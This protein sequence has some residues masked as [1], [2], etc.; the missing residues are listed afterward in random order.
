MHPSIILSVL[1]GLCLCSKG[2]AAPSNNDALTALDL[3]PSSGF[4]IADT[5]ALAIDAD[6]IRGANSLALTRTAE[7]PSG[8]V[9]YTLSKTIDRDA[10]VSFSLKGRNLDYNY[11]IKPKIDGSSLDIQVIDVS[12]SAWQTVIVPVSAPSQRTF[13]IEFQIFSEAALNAALLIDDFKLSYG[14]QVRK[15]TADG[16]TLSLSPD[17]RAYAPTERVTIEALP[18]SGYRVNS[19]ALR[20]LSGSAPE[21]SYIT[22]KTGKLSVLLHGHSVASAIF[23]AQLDM[24]GGKAWSLEAPSPY[25]QPNAQPEDFVMEAQAEGL[26]RPGVLSFEVVPSMSGNLEFS[27]MQGL[28]NHLET[29]YVTAD[30]D[31]PHTVHLAFETP[32]QVVNWI[33]HP[34]RDGYGSRANM[35]IHNLRYVTEAQAFASTIGEGSVSMA[36]SVPASDGSVTA[37]LNAFAAPGWQFIGWRSRQTGGFISH[38]ATFSPTLTHAQSFYAVFGERFDWEGK[39]FLFA[40]GGSAQISV[41][42]DQSGTIT[43]SILDTQNVSSF[44]RLP[45]E[46]YALDLP[47]GQVLGSTEGFTGEGKRSSKFPRF[48][49][50]AS[51]YQ[52]GR[53]SPSTY[54]F[55]FVPIDEIEVGLQLVAPAGA[56]AAPAGPY[57]YGSAIPLSISLSK[58]QGFEQ[59]KGDVHSLSYDIEPIANGN[60]TLAAYYRTPAIFESPIP[61]SWSSPYSFSKDNGLLTTNLSDRFASAINGEAQGP[62]TLIFRLVDTS[63]SSISVMVDA[64]GESAE[65]S[66]F[67]D[68]MVRVRLAQ[69]GPFRVSFR[70]K[71]GVGAMKLEF[72]GVHQTINATQTA[73]GGRVV[74]RSGF[75]FEAKV[76][77]VL[78]IKVEVDDR[79]TFLGWEDPDLSGS[80]LSLPVTLYQNI[81]LK[82][83]FIF[84]LGISGL[85]LPLSNFEDW[86]FNPVF[87]RF[88]T[89]DDKLV[90]DPETLDVILQGPGVLELTVLDS[91][92]AEVYREGDYIEPRIS[93]GQQAYTYIHE[94]LIPDGTTRLSIDVSRKNE[95]SYADPIPLPAM[96]YTKGFAVRPT[97]SMLGSYS[98]SGSS[99]KNVFAKGQSVTLTADATTGN[100]F[101][102][103]T[104]DASGA[105]R[106]TTVV[107][108]QHRLVAPRYRPTASLLPTTYTVGQGSN[109]LATTDEYSPSFQIKG[110]ASPSVFTFSIPADHE[111]RFDLDGDFT[112]TAKWTVDGRS[113]QLVYAGS[114]IALAPSTTARSAKLEVQ[115]DANSS[116]SLSIVNALTRN[117]FSL[118]GDFGLQT[119]NVLVTPAKEDYAWGE[120]VTISLAS[121]VP[122]SS[123]FSNL[124]TSSFDHSQTKWESSDFVRQYQVTI[125]G[126]TFVTGNVGPS[127]VRSKGLL[128]TIPS[129]AN[130]PSNELDPTGATSKAL[131]PDSIVRIETAGDKFVTFYL[132]LPEGDY[133]LFETLSPGVPIPV[134]GLGEWMRVGL[135]VPVGQTFISFTIA[136]GGV[137]YETSRISS[138]KTISGYA[139]PFISFGPGQIQIEPVNG[140]VSQSGSVTL[141]AVPDSPEAFHVWLTPEETYELSITESVNTPLPAIG[142]FGLPEEEEAGLPFGLTATG[143]VPQF[144]PPSELDTN[145][146]ILLKKGP[147]TFTKQVQGPAV[148]MVDAY[149]QFEANVEVR[150]G[151]ESYLVAHPRHNQ[152]T[153]SYFTIPAGTKTVELI[154][155]ATDDR[156]ESVINDVQL[157]NG[158]T[159]SATA[160]NAAVTLYPEK[161]YYTRGEQV[162]LFARPFDG[163]SFQQWTGDASSAQNPLTLTISQHTEVSALVSASSVSGYTGSEWTLLHQIDDRYT[164]TTVVEGPGSLALPFDTNLDRNPELRINGRLQK[165]TQTSSGHSYFLVPAGKQ[166]LHLSQST[167]LQAAPVA[168][169]PGL[170]VDLTVQSDY[171]KLSIAPE[172]QS[173]KAGDQITVDWGEKAEVYD[174]D[175]PVFIDTFGAAATL[176]LTFTVSDH[177]VGQVFPLERG[178]VEEMQKSDLFY[179]FDYE[180][181]LTVT[182]GSELSQGMDLTL[183]NSAIHLDLD[184]GGVLSFGYRREWDFKP[185]P[186][187]VRINGQIIETLW[188]G[189]DYSLNIPSSGGLVSIVSTS[190]NYY[191]IGTVH[192]DNLTFTPE[193]QSDAFKLKLEAA[194]PLRSFARGTQF[195]SSGDLDGDGVQNQRELLLGTNPGVFDFRIWA[196][197]SD[198]SDSELLAAFKQR[199][200]DQPASGPGPQSIV[201]LRGELPEHEPRFDSASALSL[202]AYLPS[203]TSIA[204]LALQIGKKDDQTGGVDWSTYSLEALT[205]GAVDVAGQARLAR[206]SFQQLPSDPALIRLVLSDR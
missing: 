93:F 42:N 5:A 103:W 165:M 125:K 183:V 196:I 8:S 128:T 173:Y 133:A 115:I 6:S 164:Y 147:I 179:I 101:L 44:E 22:S 195:T 77:E 56:V 194:V 46:A 150:I 38:D 112:G 13:S 119:E 68:N 52:G 73:H 99:P 4:S 154:Y 178:P 192:L 180:N 16:G 15:E 206:I 139:A 97:S 23:D 90:N 187:E 39:S 69:A 35:R 83:K 78:D 64:A 170:K 144:D 2:F 121:S 145:G 66:T 135:P 95:S 45:I 17:K 116:E 186:G 193:K 171:H 72:L 96:S 181:D 63:S 177:L 199:F 127:F 41:G 51:D 146:R 18:D 87:N 48:F 148:L 202:M 158:Y 36:H 60:L 102:S 105:N 25:D 152:S 61:L 198:L 85:E 168:Y 175:A 79:Y 29:I 75:P 143:E 21:R 82:P 205:P 12:G 67:F 71:S 1:I 84:D 3:S 88:E 189:N 53:F 203:R 100:Q 200:M 184:Q 204:S 24:Q 172:K 98:V 81:D 185:F 58:R 163:F 160:Q 120:K 33:L 149:L 138:I 117:R 91:L 190:I 54:T 65:A 14:R 10:V 92:S 111:F 140:V 129:S 159:L 134:E 11:T 176:P 34:T 106:T 32:P 123:V 7:K 197:E 191:W 70:S 136:D 108:N 167:R 132:Y 74:A 76:G 188:D 174:L 43:F 62:C 201:K 155:S 26:S 47:A 80:S 104:G 122:Q 59:W 130:R 107:M 156:W 57:A 182:R 50:L 162:T 113:P 169:V 31:T 9:S 142:F 109:A 114:T 137:L 49:K 89:I 126:D 37:T 151:N 94:Y 157:I 28:T 153:P 124:V 19:L 27:S 166:R 131:D 20:T 40:H 141:K 55:T 30:G 118:T 161:P 86:H 110:S